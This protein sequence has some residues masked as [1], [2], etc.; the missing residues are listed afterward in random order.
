M[1]C[2]ARTAPVARKAGVGIGTLY[3]HFPPREVLFQAVDVRDV[4]ALER[5]AG[6][7]DLTVRMRAALEMM[8]TKKAWS[9]LLRRLSD[10]PEAIG[11]CHMK[12]LTVVARHTVR[13]VPISGCGAL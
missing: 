7:D 11:S 3:R 5:R 13:P 2:S 10:Y 4:E 12:T 6:K 8:A 1:R 9:Q